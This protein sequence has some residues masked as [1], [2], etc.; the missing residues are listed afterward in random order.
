[1]YRLFIDLGLKY[2]VENE[3]FFNRLYFVGETHQ[4]CKIP[5]RKILKVFGEFF[6]PYEISERQFI[7]LLCAVV[8]FLP[9]LRRGVYR[10]ILT[11]W[12]EKIFGM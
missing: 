9:F 1:M 5:L 2:D 11:A 6:P 7:Q 8:S 12:T 10:K 4:L 3:Q